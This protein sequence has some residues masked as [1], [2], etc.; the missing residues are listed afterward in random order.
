MT[1]FYELALKTLLLNTHSAVSSRARGLIFGLI[2]YVH[3][4]TVY[5]ISR[6]SGG[7]SDSPVVDAKSNESLC[8]GPYAGFVQA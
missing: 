3:P 7:D 8:T 1:F 4:Y 2:L 6:G 5:V